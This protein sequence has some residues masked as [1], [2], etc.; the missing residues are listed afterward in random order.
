M[1]NIALTILFGL[2]LSM[3]GFS[4]KKPARYFGEPILTDTLSTLFIPTRYN[5]AF[6][7]ANKISFWGD[8]YANIVAYNFKTDS[9]RKLFEKDVYI[10]SFR[11]VYYS[12]NSR[13][14]VKIKNIT[15]KWIFLLVKFKDT[16]N[17]GRID[18]KDPTILFA[19]SPDG[20]TLK[21]LTD[22]TENVVSFENYDKQG[23]ILIKIQRDLNKDKSFKAEDGDFYFRKV[24]L[25][26]LTLGNGIEINN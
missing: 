16:N 17:S 9:Y 23:F 25:A 4:Q 22:E 20:Q 5:E 19:A 11:G 1:N 3:T 12:Y 14:D 7:S 6:L 26:D 15:T 10:E 21:Q 13:T 24:N 18:E 8:Y 2:T